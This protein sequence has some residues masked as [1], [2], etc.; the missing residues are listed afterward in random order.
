M[1][2]W[3]YGVTEERLGKMVAMIDEATREIEEDGS[4]DRCGRREDQ[5]IW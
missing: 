3:I 1:V 4:L 2:A 5:G